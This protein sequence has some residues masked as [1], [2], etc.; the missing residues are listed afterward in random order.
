MIRIP[1]VIATFMLTEIGNGPHL[2]SVFDTFVKNLLVLVV[3][4]DDRWRWPVLWNELMRAKYSLNGVFVNV[5][6]SHGT[7]EMPHAESKSSYDLLRL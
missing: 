5:T 1:T 2:T 3:G 7:T 4:E 6:R